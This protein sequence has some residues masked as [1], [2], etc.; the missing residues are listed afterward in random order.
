M[1]DQQHKDELI[2]ALSE[3]VQ[4]LTNKLLN[5]RVQSGIALKA[6]DKEIDELKKHQER[7]LKAVE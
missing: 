3:L 6:K 5:L 2:L 1:D 4:E 7:K